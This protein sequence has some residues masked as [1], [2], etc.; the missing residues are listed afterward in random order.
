MKAVVARTAVP[1]VAALLA[2]VACSEPPTKPEASP[3]ISPDEALATDLRWPR[4]P[5][6][7]P[8][9]D[10]PAV[11]VGAGDIAQCADNYQDEE[12][13]ALLDKIP[14][15]VIAVGDLAYP[16]GAPKP[17]FRPCYNDSWGVYKARTRPAPGNH[18]Y[19]FPAAAGYFK[20]FG[21][22]SNPP[23]GY[24]S[25]NLGS[26]HVVV[27]NSTPQVYLCYPP[28]ADEADPLITWVP[29]WGTPAPPL[30]PG[31]DPSPAVG[32][33]CAGDLLQQAWLVADLTKHRR[34][35]CTV[36]YFHH[37]RFSSG[38]HGNHYQMQRIWDILYR[39]RADVVISGH[40]HLYER[41][42][43][44]DPEGKPD[45]K[46]GIRQFTVGTGGAPLYPFKTTI[47]PNS[48][49]RNNETHGVIKLT[50]GDG[51]YDWEFVPVAGSTFTDSGSGRCH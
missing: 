31:V 8:A 37:P 24:Y 30:P 23:F 5:F 19:I 20:Y 12:T 45:T 44:Q 21:S 17:D 16:N 41:F 50:L 10:G 18:E 7:Q 47:E 26:W 28:E 9:P 40:D 11:L 39:F 25:Y 43:P 32:R 13:A 38:K 14:G 49:A 48:E 35:R 42:A 1:A 34:Y 46:R 3:A 27:I 15:T 33:A 36:A 22:V 29:W 6:R 51:D 2:A 4:W